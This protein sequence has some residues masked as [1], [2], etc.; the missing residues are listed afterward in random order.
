MC[1]CVCVCVCVRARASACVRAWW[2]VCVGGGGGVVRARARASIFC[3]LCMF[4]CLR[5]CF[6]N[7]TALSAASE[8][9]QIDSY[10]QLTTG[11][12]SLVNPAITP[13][14][15]INATGAHRHLIILRTHTEYLSLLC[16]FLI[17][18]VR[19]METQTPRSKWQ[20]I[21]GHPGYRRVCGLW[22]CGLTR[23]HF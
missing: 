1:V 9:S 14:L 15:V 11:A 3:F 23:F 6:Q 20:Y 18:L 5:A 21:V 19:Q 22:E 17:L 16:K 10:G 2:C 7:N 12:G 8:S 13:N 4:L